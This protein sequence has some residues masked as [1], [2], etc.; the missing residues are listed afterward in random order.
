ML[1]NFVNV[2]KTTEGYEYAERKGKDSIAFIL[3]NR[4]KQEMGLRLEY[5]PP[6][7]TW[8]LGAFGGSMD[9]EHVSPLQ[10]VQAEV[11]EEAGYVVKP[12]DVHFIG[13]Y[14]VSSQMNQFCYLFVVF[15]D[16]AQWI[17]PTTK[18]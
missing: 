12:D 7:G 1:N 13:K 14:F 8:I 17:V 9:K 16:D 10:I 18:D 11:A 4:T 15:V 2:F 5:K 3:Y 6:I